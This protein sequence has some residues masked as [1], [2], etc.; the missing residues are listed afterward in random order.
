MSFSWRCLN[1][2]ASRSVRDAILPRSRHTKCMATYQIIPLG[3]G[4][5][6]NIGVAGSDG[7]RQ[8]MLGF[9][10]MEEAEAW[11]MQDRRLTGV[12]DYQLSDGFVEQTS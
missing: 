12:A 2:S 9:T 5:G 6:F 1:Y 4:S 10:S 3:N 7:T 11:I 8:T